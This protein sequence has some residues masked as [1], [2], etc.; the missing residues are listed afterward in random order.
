MRNHITLQNLSMAKQ[1]V[2][3]KTDSEKV[4]TLD[5]LGVAM[6]RDRTFLSNEPLDQYLAAQQYQLE[7]IAKGL[8]QVAARRP[9]TMRR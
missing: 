3:F 4:N 8:A 5:E 6:R 7:E 2:N 9:T 1:N